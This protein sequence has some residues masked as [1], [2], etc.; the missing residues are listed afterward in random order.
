MQK[1]FVADS[2]R[3]EHTETLEDTSAPDTEDSID[4]EMAPSSNK[5]VKIT[6]S[7]PN[8]S[9]ESAVENVSVLNTSQNMEIESHLGQTSECLPEQSDSTTNEE[10]CM[11]ELSEPLTSY[12]MNLA[13][14]ASHVVKQNADTPMEK[15]DTLE[16]TDTNPNSNSE[17]T[18]AG[19]AH[20]STENEREE[21]ELLQ[22]FQDITKDD[23]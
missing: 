16:E 12:S 19:Q 8:E 22:C 4:N 18:V 6:D 11:Q 21:E 1:E 10:R 7:H 15:L 23:N 17:M 2:P 9:T 20:L 3:V 13:S 5:K 14:L